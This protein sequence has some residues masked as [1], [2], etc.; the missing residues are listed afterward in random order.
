[1]GIGLNLGLAKGGS[2]SGMVR[3]VRRSDIGS[4]MYLLTAVCLF[5]LSAVHLSKIFRFNIT[6][7]VRMSYCWEVDKTL[8]LPV[9]YF[10]FHFIHLLSYTKLARFLY[11]YM[12]IY[13]CTRQIIYCKWCWSRTYKKKLLKFH[14]NRMMLY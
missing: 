4:Q 1:M 14:S 2:Y 7:E 12:P 8:L 11:I 10:H 13:L 9:I 6:P 3:F 5:Q